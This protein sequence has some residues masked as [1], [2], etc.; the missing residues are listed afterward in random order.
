MGRKG[1]R[2]RRRSRRYDLTVPRPALGSADQV[3]LEG[4]ANALRLFAD[5]MTELCKRKGASVVSTGPFGD[6]K[7][8]PLSV[9]SPFRVQPRALDTP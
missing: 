4:I 9:S 1:S 5:A 3:R 6:E 7:R 2:K 8:G